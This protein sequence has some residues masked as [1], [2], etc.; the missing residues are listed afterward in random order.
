MGFTLP[1]DYWL[2]KELKPYVDDAFSKI[3]KRG[4][5]NGDVLL[6]QWHRFL[7]GDPTVTWT[8]IWSIVVLEHW[9]TNVIDRSADA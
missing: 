5:L 3:S 2:K 7:K 6:N 8:K 4:I 1:W 9:M